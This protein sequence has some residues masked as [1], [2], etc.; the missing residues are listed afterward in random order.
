MKRVKVLKWY[1]DHPIG[2][3]IE[4]RDRDAALLIPRG[5]VTEDVSESTNV[6]AKEPKKKGKK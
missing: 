4:V 6:S 1:N 2:S 3:I 5:V